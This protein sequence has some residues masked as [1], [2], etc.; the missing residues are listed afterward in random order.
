MFI[1][2]AILVA[3]RLGL[4]LGCRKYLLK[5]LYPDLRSLSSPTHGSDI[6]LDTLPAPSTTP[7]S[8]NPTDTAYLHGIVASLLFSWTFAEC[9]MLFI[10]L[11][12]Q[13]ADIMS[14]DARLI[15]WR[16]SLFFLVVTI[17]ATIPASYSLVLALGNAERVTFGRLCGPRALLNLIPVVFFLFAFSYIPLPPALSTTDTTTAIVSRLIVVGTVFIGALSG[18]GA[19]SNCWHSLPFLSNSKPAPSEAEIHV[20]EQ[21]LSN[22]QNDLR[23]R[24]SAAERRAGEASQQSWMSRVGTTFRG[25]DDL[26]QEMR[27]LESL[28][29]QMSKN[30]E[31]LRLRRELGLHSQTIRGRITGALQSLLA[32]Y[33]VTRILSCL[34]NIAFLPSQRSASNVNYSDLLANVLAYGVSRISASPIPM[35]DVAAVSRQLS[36]ALVGLIILTSIRLVLRGVTRLLHIT[37]RSLGASLMLLFL[38]QVMATYLLSTIIQMRSSFPPPPSASDIVNLFSTVPEYEVFG[39]L[40]DWTFLLTATASAVVRWGAKKVNGYDDD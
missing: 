26:S 33:C 15:N 14:S 1:E 22:T 11:V 5:T 2:T 32:V 36:L 10:L 19:V 9:C 6:E 21:A 30:L 39:S 8:A 17:I 28:E 27:G 34:Y 3:L 12:M 23:Q 24:R 7:K 20:A 16:F 40:F 29:Y 35:E 18:F 37:S 13:G 4:L 25:G 38:A 31:A